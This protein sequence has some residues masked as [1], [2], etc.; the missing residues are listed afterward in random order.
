MVAVV[1]LVNTVVVAVFMVK[2]S[3]GTNTVASSAQVVRRSGLYIGSACVLFGLA[4]QRT[5]GLT[6]VLLLLAALVHVVGEMRHSAG[7]W[8][9]SF[10]LPPDRLQGQYAGVNSAAFGLSASLAPLVMTTVVAVGVAG[11]LGLAVLFV[12]VAAALVP[13]V[14]WA[15][16]NRPVPVGG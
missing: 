4:G 11:W 14:A 1:F 7:S 15:E 12:T 13:V 10:G 3:G 2:T 8:G 16:R 9:V 5:V 6:I